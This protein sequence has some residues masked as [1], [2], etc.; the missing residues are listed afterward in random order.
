MRRGFTLIELLVVIAIIA[1]LAA[2]LFPVFAKARE[3]AR[4]ASC[5]SNVKQI[6]LGILMYVQDHDERTPQGWWWNPGEDVPGRNPCHTYRID[7]QAYI[8][9]WQLFSCPSSAVGC[10][11]YGINPNA[12]NRAI[13]AIQQPA[14]M[15]M[16]AEAAAWPRVPPGDRLDPVSWGA[17]TGSAHWQVAWP[18]S[19]PY[20]GTGCGDCTRRPYVVHNEGLNIGYVDGH[21]KWQ[22][23]RNVV[24]DPLLWNN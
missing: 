13:G 20:E 4:Q 24:T 3:K 15:C 10:A 11:T 14:S 12:C 8:R 5:A 17:P 16:V 23:G 1:I 18:G 7:I 9:N 6:V 2:I 19:A 21:V 22:K